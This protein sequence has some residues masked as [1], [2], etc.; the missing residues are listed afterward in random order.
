MCFC[1]DCDNVEHHED[2]DDIGN[3]IENC[4]TDD[5]NDKNKKKQMFNSSTF[6][7]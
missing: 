3:D 2:L 4:D 7:A 6:F 1:M 5:D